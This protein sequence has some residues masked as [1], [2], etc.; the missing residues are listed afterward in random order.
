MDMNPNYKEK[1]RE[2]IDKNGLWETS[3]RLSIPIVQLFDMSDYTIKN[4]IDAGDLI[5]YMLKNGN[6]QG[7]YK[8]FEIFINQMEGAISWYY[9]KPDNIEIDAYATPFW[10]NDE[11]IPISL[12]IFRDGVEIADEFETIYTSYNFSSSDEVKKWWE[13]FYLPKVYQK[14]KYLSGL[15]LVRLN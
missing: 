5:T 10:E 12:L 4:P 15:S 1:F 2:L 8:K 6:L 14:I 11:G 3:K 7:N 13:E 9:R